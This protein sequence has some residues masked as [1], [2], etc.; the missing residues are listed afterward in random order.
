[1]GRSGLSAN[2]TSIL[3]WTVLPQVLTSALVSLFYRVSPS[4]RPT[5]PPNASPQH[6]ALAQARSQNH[7]RRARIVLVFGYLA[8]SVLSV[9]YAQSTALEQNY[10]SLLG[11]SRATVEQGPSGTVKSHWRRLARRYHPDKVG[12]AGEA[13]FVRLRT[14][15]ETL[16]NDSKRW[17]YERFG[18]EVHDWGAKLVT[19]REYL[20]TGALRSG[21]WWAFALGSIIVFSFFRENERK[22]NFVSRAPLPARESLPPIL[23]IA[24]A[25]SFRSGAT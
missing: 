2:A 3:C 10:Y 6:L 7:H 4:A 1:M 25:T 19:P 5:I 15:V 21:V 9:Y 13:Y 23:T 11:L 8:Y 18:P 24:R 17:A 20:Q 14:G 22:Y 16:D 12:K